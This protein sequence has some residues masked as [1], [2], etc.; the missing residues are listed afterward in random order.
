MIESAEFM[1][2]FMKKLNNNEFKKDFQPNKGPDL[3][4]EF[5][6]EQLAAFDKLLD[7]KLLDDVTKAQ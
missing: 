5:A 1:N 4:N 2:N 7:S 3:S 6:K